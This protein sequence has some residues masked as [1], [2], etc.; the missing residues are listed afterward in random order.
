MCIH[1][2]IN[3]YTCTYSCMQ[4]MYSNWAV[5]LNHFR[6]WLSVTWCIQGDLLAMKCEGHWDLADSLLW[7]S[8]SSRSFFLSVFDIINSI[9]CVFSWSWTAE[10]PEPRGRGLMLYFDLSF[11]NH[12]PNHLPNPTI[13]PTIPRVSPSI[14]SVSPETFTA[15]RLDPLLLSGSLA[16]TTQ[17]V[18]LLPLRGFDGHLLARCALR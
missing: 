12:V 8:H 7:S 6:I 14:P 5:F 4:N 13:H 10:K 15:P 16:L 1:V 9:P 18:Q 3:V 17:A 2:Y 11:P